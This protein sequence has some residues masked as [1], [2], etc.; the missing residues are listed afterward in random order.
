MSGQ[1][2]ADGNG[3]VPQSGDERRQAHR[4]A[5][6]LNKIFSA[7][8]TRGGETVQCYLYIID[9][10]EGGIR[11]TS[12]YSFPTDGPVRVKFK[13]DEPLEVNVKVVWSKTLEGGTNVYG[14]PG[15]CRWRSGCRPQSRFHCHC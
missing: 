12:D 9:I 4:Q 5:L 7:E 8:I 15:C 3:S 1:E 6:K 10:S 13:F 14:M 2:E 11:I